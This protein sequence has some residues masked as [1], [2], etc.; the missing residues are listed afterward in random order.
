[1]FKE[2]KEELKETRDQKMKKNQRI[3]RH[4]KI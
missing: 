4:K 2:M 3:S 1:M